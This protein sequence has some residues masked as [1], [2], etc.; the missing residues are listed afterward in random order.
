MFIQSSI[1]TT[2]YVLNLRVLD[3]KIIVIFIQCNRSRNDQ[4]ILG[5]HT[6]KNIIFT[7]FSKPFT[8]FQYWNNDFLILGLNLR[9]DRGR[10]DHLN[11]FRRMEENF[12]LS[13]L[14][15]F[16]F[17]D[18]T[19]DWYLIGYFSQKVISLLDNGRI[20]L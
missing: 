17:L 7:I 11:G 6:L 5:S 9:D 12:R 2:I 10:L 13:Q 16:Q 3:T 4:F 1:K 20:L 19:I 8:R 14:H 18:R 15:I